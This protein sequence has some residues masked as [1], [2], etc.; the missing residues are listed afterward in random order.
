MDEDNEGF[1]EGGNESEETEKY[2][3]KLLEMTEKGD[4]WED[5]SGHVNQLLQRWGELLNSQ[6]EY[7]DTFWQAAE[8]AMKLMKTMLM[9]CER[10]DRR[11]TLPRT[12]QDTDQ[13][14]MFS[15]MYVARH[16]RG[17]AIWAC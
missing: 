1:D 13:H 17:L 4:S 15:G 7:R 3:E 5:V 2:D 10:I 6:K 8:E 9:K 11:R 14:T 12:W 16:L